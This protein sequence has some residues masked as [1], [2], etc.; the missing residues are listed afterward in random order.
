MKSKAMTVCLVS[1]T[2][3]GVRRP[4]A[5]TP[6]VQASGLKRL[7]PFNGNLAQPTWLCWHASW[8]LPTM[9]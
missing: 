9:A 4:I 7:L 8:A 2:T 6:C 5:R 1:S 3:L